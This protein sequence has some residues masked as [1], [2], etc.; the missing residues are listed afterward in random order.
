MQPPFPQVTRYPA[1]RMPPFSMPSICR[2]ILLE[3]DASGAGV[4]MGFKANPS[5]LPSTFTSTPAGHTASCRHRHSQ[6]FDPS[7]LSLDRSDLLSTQTP[8]DMNLF[9]TFV[10]F[11]TLQQSRS[12]DFF[13][14][15]YLTTLMKTSFSHSLFSESSG[16][17]QLVFHDSNLGSLGISPQPPPLFDL[18]G[19]GFFLVFRVD[20]PAPFSRVF[21]PNTRSF[22]LFCSVACW[23]RSAL[24]N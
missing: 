6:V 13:G 2:L 10:S 12:P 8:C 22:P 11:P 21:F 17:H 18:G 19:G 23:I 15:R 4:D 9:S 14:R 1:A 5:H 7:T 16:V 24:Q 3:R 20:S